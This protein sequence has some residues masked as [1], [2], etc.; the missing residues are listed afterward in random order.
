MHEPESEDRDNYEFRS[1]AVQNTGTK[2]V[3]KKLGLRK[4]FLT[5]SSVISLLGP[6]SDYGVSCFEMLHMAASH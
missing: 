4:S 5:G 1:S 3:S 2:L 6:D